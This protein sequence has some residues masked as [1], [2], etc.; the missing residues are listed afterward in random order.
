MRCGGAADPIDTTAQSGDTDTPPETQPEIISR[1]LPEKDYGGFEFRILTSDESNHMRTVF[2]ID[3]EG[4]NGDHLNDAIFYR[5]AAVE[6]ALGVQ[7]TEI[8]DAKDTYQKTFTASVMADDDSYD[9]L[10]TQADAVLKSGYKIGLDVTELPYVDLT[11]EWWDGD[12]MEKAAIGGANYGLSGS[13]NLVDDNSTW[14]LFFNKELAE[15]NKVG[16]LYQMVYDGKW[17]LDMLKKLCADVK[18]D[19][20]GDSKLDYLDQWGLVASRGAGGAMF[21]S[22]GA[23]LSTLE[24]DGSLTLTVDDSRNV[25]ALSKVFDLFSSGEVLVIDRDIPD[26]VE[27]LSN[28]DYAPKMFNDGRALFYEGCL[29]SLSL[30]RDMEQEF[31][32][33]PNPKLDE[34]Q[35]N[36]ISNMQEW[37]GTMLLVPRTA[38]DPE[39]TSIILEAMAS[40]SEYYVIPAYYDVQLTRKY[41]RDDESEAILDLLS[42]NRVFDLAYVF[43]FGKVR[44]LT[45]VL[46]GTSDTSASTFASLKTACQAAYEATYQEIL[47][48]N[49]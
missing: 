16:D 28:Y 34:H 9:L 37:S 6:D 27:G 19:L 33:L 30:F 39:R 3:V 31:G 13:I 2:E 11:R 22:A 23:C 20:N 21:W 14:L 29:Y 36:Y 4:Q 40:A 10:V 26:S 7:I 47:D 49:S 43:N 25:K 1:A 15:E 42:E 35:E 18:Q 17:T 24:E 5:N 12:L 48:A 38:P 41:S 46:H 45:K 8:R 44:N 32:Y